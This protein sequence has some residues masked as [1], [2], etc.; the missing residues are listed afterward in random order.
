[1][2]HK[3]LL[4]RWNEDRGFGFIK[5]SSDNEEIF[6]HVSALKHMV[7]RPVVG[8][9]IHYQLNIDGNSKKKAVNANIEGEFIALI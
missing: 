8:D 1:M 7:R 5:P 4:V 3:G 6:I 9:V 2:I